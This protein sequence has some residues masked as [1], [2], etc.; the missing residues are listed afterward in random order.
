ME[1]VVDGYDKDD[2]AKKLLIELSVQGY[3]NHGYSLQDD[4]IWYKG[5]IWLG[6]QGEAHK[7]ILLALHGSALGWHSGVLATY[8]KVK[9]PFAWLSM[10]QDIISY[11][12]SCHVYQQAKSEYVCLPGKL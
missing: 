11:I 9:Q 5:W 8:Q 4:V 6:N 2:R 7:D 12:K 10:K 1:T 3:N